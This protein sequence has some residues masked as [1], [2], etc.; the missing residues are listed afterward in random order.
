NPELWNSEN[1]KTVISTAHTFSEYLNKK[2]QKEKIK[3][4]STFEIK[5]ALPLYRKLFLIVKKDYEAVL[6]SKYF[7]IINGFFKDLNSS[8][9]NLELPLRIIHNDFNPRNIAVRANGKPV[10]YDWELAVR[11]L[12]HRDV[13]EFLSFVL[14]KNFTKTELLAYLHFHHEIAGKEIAWDKWKHGYLRTL[15]EYILS[16]VLFYN[17]ADILIKLKFSNRI[18][19]SSMRI[20]KILS[21]LK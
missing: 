15:K 13:I 12:P 14:P 4:V 5:R 8:I 2:D 1:I 6:G 11:N 10:V 21:G 19:I 7:N 3:F 16:R 9:K 17:A 18:F 20:Y